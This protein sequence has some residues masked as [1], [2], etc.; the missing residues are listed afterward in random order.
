MVVSFLRYNQPAPGVGASMVSTWPVRAASGPQ[1]AGGYSAAIM[2]SVVL[3]TPPSA[4]AKQ[5]RSSSTVCPTVDDHV[6]PGVMRH[7]GQVG[8]S[9]QRAVWLTAQENAIAHRDDEQTS[10]WQE[11]KA[12]RRAGDTGDEL[13]AAVQIHRGDLSRA[14]VDEPQAIT[15]PAGRLAEHESG[16]QST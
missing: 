7:T 3:S 1:L 16:R 8:V 12:H 11:A 4:Q 10:I 13:L 15:M 9:H 14:E 5:P 2:N 6:A